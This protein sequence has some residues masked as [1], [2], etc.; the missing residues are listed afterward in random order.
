MSIV[1]WGVNSD[2][3][4]Y[5]SELDTIEC[6]DCTVNG[7]TYSF[8]VGEFSIHITEH[9]NRGDNV[10]KGILDNF[11]KERDYLLENVIKGS[12]RNRR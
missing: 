1:R 8:P 12:K 4:M 11:E 6:H 9:V 2:V 5:F 7:G 3:Y 10:P